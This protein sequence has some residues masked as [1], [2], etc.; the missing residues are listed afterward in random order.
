M[1]HLEIFQVFYFYSA[2]GMSGDEKYLE[3]KLMELYGHPLFTLEEDE[4]PVRATFQ[5][6]FR[7]GQRYM[8]MRSIEE[9]IVSHLSN[10]ELD[11]LEY[12]DIQYYFQEDLFHT[13]ITH[14]YPNKPPIT[15]TRPLQGRPL[16]A[17]DFLHCNLHRMIKL[18]KLKYTCSNEFGYV[19]TAFMNRLTFPPLLHSI[20]I[21]N[22]NQ[23]IVPL[24]TVPHLEI[25]KIQFEEKR[26]ILLNLKCPTIVFDPLDFDVL[27]NG[28]EQLERILADYTIR[29]YDERIICTRH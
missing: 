1:Y 11:R 3:E 4:I 17:G 14:Q 6:M 13:E 7:I 20:I 10:L 29:V 24:N 15:S 19:N 9:S 28:V 23:L 8:C 12:L 26:D 16:D 22:I 2:I 5:K 27:E 25:T 21:D 18:K